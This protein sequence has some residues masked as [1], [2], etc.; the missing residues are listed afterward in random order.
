MEYFGFV[1]GL[2][3]L[4]WEIRQNNLMWVVGILSALAYA[5]VF[6]QSALWAAMLFQVYYF[7]VSIYGLISWRRDKKLVAAGRGETPAGALASEADANEAASSVAAAS[8]VAA[9]GVITYRLITGRALAVSGVACAVI[10]AAI[11]WLLARFT[12]DPMPVMDAVVATLGIVATYWLGK[13]YLHQWL[14][15][16]AVNVLSVFMFI[17]Q[18]LYLTAFLYFLYTLCAFYGFLHWKKKGVEISV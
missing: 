15:W 13:A 9:S 6:A 17:S 12:G 3:Y 1:T 14:L 2:L 11:Y 4:I 10:F 16:V 8:E 5:V 7:F 18:E